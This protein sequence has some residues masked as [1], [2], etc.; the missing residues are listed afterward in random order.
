MKIVGIIA[1]FATVGFVSC[2]QATGDGPATTLIKRLEFDNYL[3]GVAWSS[4]GR[5]LVTTEAASDSI[6]VWDTASWSLERVIPQH[7]GGGTYPLIFTP[8]GRY[9]ITPA[10]SANDGTK[11]VDVF[12]FRNGERVAQLVGPNPIPNY[13]AA[14]FPGG[15]ALSKNGRTLYAAFRFPPRNAPICSYD[16]TTWTKRACWPSEKGVFTLIAGREEDEV[17]ASNAD[18]TI[19]I[20]NAKSKAMIRHIEGPGDIF[21]GA[22]A[23][24]PSGKYLATIEGM[25]GTA[26]NSTTGKIEELGSKDPFRIWDY[27]SG[28]KLASL[29]TDSRI[30]HIAF[31]L[32]GKYLVAPSVGLGARFSTFSVF[33]IPDLKEVQ[34]LRNS[35]RAGIGAWFSPDGTRLAIG[36][37]NAVLV[38]S[39]DEL[40]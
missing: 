40:R 25:E 21:L 19:Q 3:S 24:D 18:G 10:S 28:R 12:D 2:S 37:A 33:R 17:V 9:L 27:V 34:A 6:K 14:N 38:Y 22:M 31:S 1:L 7:I 23:L 36:G 32:T 26:L 35:G 8:D 11:A 5:Y 20:W 13:G 29:K 15:I 39:F 4:D 16:T 30:G